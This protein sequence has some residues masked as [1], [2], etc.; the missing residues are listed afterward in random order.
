MSD[1]SDIL[2]KLEEINKSLQDIN[3]RQDINE[4]FSESDRLIDKIENRVEDSLN[5]IQISF[6]RIHDKVFNFNNIM[7][8]SF[9]VLGTF[10]SNSP[11]LPL[12]TAIFPIA[13]LIYLIWIDIR[14]M[15]IHRF[16]S[17]EMQWTSKDRESFGEKIKNQTLFSL[18]AIV[19]SLGCLIYILIKLF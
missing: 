13:N 9:M 6:D 7:I 19:L 17:N 4:Q 2:K 14:Q 18:G 10:P 5:Q 12:W 11:I 8:A 1:N 15:E 16:A 3:R